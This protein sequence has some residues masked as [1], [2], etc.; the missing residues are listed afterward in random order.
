LSPRALFY[1]NAVKSQENKQS[2]LRGRVAL[3]TGATRGIGF[4][5]ARALASEGCDLI[6]CGRD[7]AQLAK[8]E[9]DLSGK[10]VRVLAQGCDVRDEGSI[11]AMFE[12]IRKQSD[13]LD[14]LINNV[15]ITHPQSP[16]KELPSKEWNDVIASTLTGMFLVTRHAL[17]I[18]HRGASIVNM[19]SVSSRQVFPRQAA[20]NSAKHGALGFTNTLR[21]ELR[22]EGIRVIAVLPG[23]TETPIWDTLWPEAPREKMIKPETVAQAVV[24]A[25]KLPVESTVE[26]IVIR[27]ITGSL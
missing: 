12:A 11:V 17:T 2:S 25:L 20:Y 16:I 26:E 7:T 4:S 13:R 18:M 22:A 21:E 24:D 9:T 27:P 5:I 23:P 6:I 14:I 19:L 8:V 1:G 15:G 10:R 3:V